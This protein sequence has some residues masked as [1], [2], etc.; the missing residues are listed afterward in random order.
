MNLPYFSVKNSLCLNDRYM[1][2]KMINNQNDITLNRTY[3]IEQQSPPI[4]HIKMIAN[5]CIKRKP[6]VKGIVFH[7]K[8]YRQECYQSIFVMPFFQC[9]ELLKVFVCFFLFP[10]LNT[11]LIIVWN[12]L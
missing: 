6:K 7:K 9:I 10:Y 2:E 1:S 11:A 12:K 5:G 8:K 3:P 4:V